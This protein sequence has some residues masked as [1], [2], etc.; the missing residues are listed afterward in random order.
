[1]NVGTRFAGSLSN[2]CRDI[3]VWTKTVNV[4]VAL[5]EKLYKK[6]HK[7][8][9]IEVWWSHY[10]GNIST[11][12]QSFM[13]TVVEKF[14]SKPHLHDKAMLLTCRRNKTEIIF[15]FLCQLSSVSCS[16]DC[17]VTSC[18]DLHPAKISQRCSWRRCRR[19]EEWS[20]FTCWWCVSS[21]CCGC[22]LQ[23]PPLLRLPKP[24]AKPGRD[25][26]SVV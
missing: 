19:P 16:P 2:I 1:M 8:S 12:I 15:H 22:S 21:L 17:D 25:R 20:L 7:K 10:L 13:D 11:S 24:G 3:S 23:A 5:E 6:L 9:S 14:T 18:F 26:K 4:V